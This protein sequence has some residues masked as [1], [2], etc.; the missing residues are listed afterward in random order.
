LVPHASDQ[1]Q[2]LDLLT[3]AL[4]KQRFSNSGSSRL[5]N[6]HSNKPVRILGAW[7]AASAPHHNVEAFMNVGLIPL[8]AQGQFYLRVDRGEARRVRG[9]GEMEHQIP[10]AP[11]P[12]EARRRFDFPRGTEAPE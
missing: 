3:F 9:L 4:M 1:I 7:F 10:E 11:I 5:H 2:S 12:R 8:E 6:A